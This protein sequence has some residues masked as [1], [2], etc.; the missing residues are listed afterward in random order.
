MPVNSG[1]RTLL[2][3]APRGPTSAADGSP[4]GSHDWTTIVPV[5]NGPSDEAVTAI[6]RIC[7]LTWLPA[8]IA[9][10]AA[11]RSAQRAGTLP[12]HLDPDGL[13]AGVQA[14]AQMWANH[15]EP[16]DEREADRLREAITALVRQLVRSGLSS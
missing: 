13:I 15:P 3:K 9:R 1:N 5:A 12:S 2:Y 6:V 7:V 16:T 10:R 8:P 11:I 14:I 4:L